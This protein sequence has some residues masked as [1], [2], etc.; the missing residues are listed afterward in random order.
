MGTMDKDAQPV[1]HR[2]QTLAGAYFTYLASKFPVMCASDEF[3]FM[4]R[5]E[6][7][8]RFYERLDCMEEGSINDCIE[9]VKAYRRDIDL[10]RK[11]PVFRKVGRK[12]NHGLTPATLE[13]YIDLLLLQSSMSALCIEFEE[14]RAWMH[15]PLL[16]LKI[17]FI[18]IDHA[19]HKPASTVQEA[20]KRV[21]ARLE[22]LPGLLEQAG[23]NLQGVPES[24]HH[25]ALDMVEDCRGYLGKIAA[26]YP[27]H[28]SFIEAAGKA[29]VALTTFHTYLK[30]TLPSSEN[31]SAPDALLERTLRD[32]FQV[33]RDISEVLRIA[34]TQWDE[35]LR[36]LREIEGQ[37]GSGNSWLELYRSYKPGEL[38]TCGTLELY[39]EENKRLREF[40]KFQGFS[41]SRVD[42][43]LRILQT[44]RYLQSVRGSASFSAA[45]SS[46]PREESFFY[47]TIELSHAADRGRLR[48]RLHREYRFL[49]AHETFPGHHL[50]DHTRRN[51]T[52]PVRRQIESP[53]FYE[54][55]ATY[56]ESLLLETGYVKGPLERLV[57]H[58]RNLWR[59]ARCLVDVG[60]TTGL[61]DMEESQRLLESSG[62]C[63]QEA[64]AQIKRFRLNPGY[65]LCYSLGSHEILKLRK[66][67]DTLLTNG[68][69]HRLLLEGGELPFSLIGLKLKHLTLN[70][71]ADSGPSIDRDLRR[72]TSRA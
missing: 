64:A 72:R 60:L 45:F 59:A 66:S 54:G 29:A 18:G 34:R 4:P 41:E 23:R 44:P 47:I 55:W 69:F 35:N 52:N 65:Q 17:G 51:I 33:S 30:N 56:A 24:Y 70:D 19:L 7:A 67:Y 11:D 1:H 63:A 12:E 2:I 10:L 48:D 39:R 58:K 9:S 38:D 25:G 62:F 40:F 22:A 31:L 20:M 42:A 50:L 36:L 8:C 5:A 28:D 46:D 61:M 49:T 21:R 16:Y 6:E 71:G 53:L 26:A 15:D 13:D 37:V 3:H 68:S 27:E 32:H 14:H 57:F 43:P